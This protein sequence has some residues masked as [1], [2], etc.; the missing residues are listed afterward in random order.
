M[1]YVF[2]EIALCVCVCALVCKCDVSLLFDAVVGVG[3]VIIGGVC[4]FYFNV[5][6]ARE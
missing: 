6:C 5:N 4:R 2:K 3:V 1:C